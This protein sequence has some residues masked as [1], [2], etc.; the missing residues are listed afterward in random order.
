MQKSLE[1]IVAIKSKLPAEEEIVEYYKKEI[2]KI[3]SLYHS[4]E[5]LIQE[6]KQKVFNQIHQ[7]QQES[8]LLIQSI[9]S[10][11][12]QHEQDLNQ[13]SI[14]IQSNYDKIIREMELQPFQDVISQY[15]AKIREIEKYNIGVQNK[16]IEYQQIDDNEIA[17]FKQ[18]F[19]QR[20]FLIKN[21]FVNILGQQDL[22]DIKYI[23]DTVS[24]RKEAKADAALKAHAPNQNTS[25]SNFNITTC[26]SNSNMTATS[27]QI[28]CASS[29]ANL[30][31]NTIYPN[32]NSTSNITS[33]IGTTRASNPSNCFNPANASTTKCGSNTHSNH[34]LCE[35]P[36]SV[37]QLSNFEVSPK[38]SKGG[39]HLVMGEDRFCSN[40]KSQKKNYKCVQS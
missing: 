39:V 20:P 12:N 5:V 36:V 19:N 1:Q 15:L 32:I 16:Y 2:E 40:Q 37:Q 3:N 4:I 28:V 18:L 31:S 33:N 7:K 35:E 23:S 26:N 10:Q 8:I 29:N 11:Q 24:Q 27:N 21:K 17:Q 22:Y 14:D 25:S 30:S 9:K 13:H 6:E 38:Q 34:N